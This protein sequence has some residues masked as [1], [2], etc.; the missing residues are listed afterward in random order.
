MISIYEIPMGKVQWLSAARR[1]SDVWMHSSIFQQ[2]FPEVF[3]CCFL[4]S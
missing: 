2:E 4:T 1:V 3:F